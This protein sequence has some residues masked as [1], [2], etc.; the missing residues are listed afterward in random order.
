MPLGQVVGQGI[1]CLVWEK[2]Q[3][4]ERYSSPD[5]KKVGYYRSFCRNF[6]EAVSPLTNLLK[7][8][9]TFLWL[10]ACRQAFEQVKAQMVNV[11]VMAASRFDRP[12]SLQV[13]AS[14][15]GAGAVLLLT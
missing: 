15:M 14:H 6:S 5:T 9:V 4:V 8:K 7:S 11:P 3:T 12:F 1:V 2:V 13:D 10:P